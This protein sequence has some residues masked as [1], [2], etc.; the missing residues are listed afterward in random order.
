[1]KKENAVYDMLW[2]ASDGPIRMC[3]LIQLPVSLD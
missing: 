3:K 1:V 2:S